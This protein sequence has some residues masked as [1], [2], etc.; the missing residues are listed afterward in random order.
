MKNIKITAAVVL[1]EEEGDFYDSSSTFNL[2]PLNQIIQS[3]VPYVAIVTRKWLAV[4]ATSTPSE[5]HVERNSRIINRSRR[6]S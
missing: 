4:C 6:W 5:Q 3:R 1:S 2:A